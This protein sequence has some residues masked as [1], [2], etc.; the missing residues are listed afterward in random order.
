MNGDYNQGMSTLPIFLGRNRTVKVVF[1]LSFIPI[2]LLL[3]YTFIYYF[4]NNLFIATIYFLVLIIAPLIYFTIKTYDAKTVQEFKH[5][6]NILKLVI[7]FGI[8]SI[9]VV[10]LNIIYNA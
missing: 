4:V 5:L 10:S 1:A 7:F 9:A 3:K 6:S 2:A 8:I